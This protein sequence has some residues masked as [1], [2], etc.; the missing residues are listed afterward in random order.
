MKTKFPYAAILAEQDPEFIAGFA[1]GL[2]VIEVFGDQDQRLT[3]SQVAERVGLER[4][5]VRR[6]LLTLTRLGYADY[7]GKFFSLTPRMLRLGYAYLSSTPFISIV[8]PF[9]EELTRKTGETSAVAKLDGTQIVYL[10][11][12]MDPARALTVSRSV[13]GR[14]PAYGASLGR[15]ILAS[16]PEDQA[17]ALLESA[18]RPKVT[19]KTLT[20]IPDLMAELARVRDQGYSINDEE[21]G[22]GLRS[23]AVPLVDG[24]GRVTAGLNIGVVARHV[25]VERM[26]AEFLPLMLDIQRRLRQLIA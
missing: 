19:D 7:D 2:A 12:A 6:C 4:A 21:T 25:S 14:L 15:V 1:K 13:G 24:A 11:R 16:W 23:I 22:Q 10:A 20:A 26:L 18:E 9:L 3:I 17:R 8:Q 5:T